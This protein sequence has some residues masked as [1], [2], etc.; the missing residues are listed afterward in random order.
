MLCTVTTV[1]SRSRRACRIARQANGETAP[2]WM[3]TTSGLRRP[4]TGAGDPP[5]G[6]S[7]GNRRTQ[8]TATRCTAGTFGSRPGDGVAVTIETRCPAASCALANSST[9]TSIPPSRG[10]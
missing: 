2:V 6:S 7:H 3:C 9:C 4:S 10:R 5:T 8:G 1:G